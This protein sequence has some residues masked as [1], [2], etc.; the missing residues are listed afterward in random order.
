MKNLKT[1]IF[2]C[3]A[4]K[5]LFV[6]LLVNLCLCV[7]SFEILAYDNVVVVI[8]P[9]HGG[10]ASADNETNSGAVYHGLYEKDINLITAQALYDELTQY[11]NVTVY[12]TRDEDVE[13]PIERRAEFAAEVNADLLVSIHYNASA[14]HNLY[15]AEAF[16]SAFGDCNGV[17]NA[18]AQICLDE[19]K[20]YG[21]IIKDVK[22]RIG[23][24]GKDYYGIIRYASDNDIPAVILEHGYLDNDK[25][26][27]RIKSEDI[28]K[29]LGRIDAA[30]IAKFYG[31]EKG[32]VKENVG[33]VVDVSAP[34]EDVLPDTTKPVGVKL[35]IDKYNSNKGDIDFTLY[36]YDDESKLMYYGF[37]LGDDVDEDTVFYD[38]E[39]W[40]GDNG[41]LTGRYHIQ[42]GYEG[43]ITASVMNV[44]QLDAKSNTVELIPDEEAEDDEEDGT[45]TYAGSDADTAAKG[46]TDES[47]ADATPE[48][49]GAAASDG[50]DEISWVIG[51]AEDKEKAAK[52]YAIENDTNST[53]KKSYTG[54]ILAGLAAAMAASV[55]LVIFISNANRKR[56]RRKRKKSGRRTGYDWMD[57]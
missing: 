15:G 11:E 13:V 53:V 47:A 33:P 3:M 54:F 32:V 19:W 43:K 6:I 39:L 26:Y 42:P 29:E 25:D 23:K 55:L 45:L 12:M 30:A 22:T 21:S 27:L 37:M 41:K 24:S 38:L 40:D 35:V 1:Q 36:A 7:F 5:A 4:A 14:D 18:F 48:V 28:W 17:G 10:E 56:R 9:G 52:A 2:R 46:Q 16:V 51:A 50:S 34:S 20:D 57:D 49:M 31:L 8:D 44:Y